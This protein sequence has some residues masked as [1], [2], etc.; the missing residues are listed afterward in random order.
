LACKTKTKKKKNN[1]KV[2]KKNEEMFTRSFFEQ[3]SGVVNDGQA[4]GQVVRQENGG[5]PDARRMTDDEQWP[6]AS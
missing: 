4:Y 1:N 6:R 2:K 5:K 3:R